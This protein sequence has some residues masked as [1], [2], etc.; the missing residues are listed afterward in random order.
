MEMSKETV[1]FTGLLVCGLV[2][3]FMNIYRVPLS[4]L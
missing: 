1:V 3:F 2:F 4:N